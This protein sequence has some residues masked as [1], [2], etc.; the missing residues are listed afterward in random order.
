M[1]FFCGFILG[2]DLPG[3]QKNM[4]GRLQEDSVIRHCW[5]APLG[6]AD[7]SLSVAW[8]QTKVSEVKLGLS[9]RRC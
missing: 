3:S 4:S 7:P 5:A 8:K 1:F 9:C 6:W 2:A